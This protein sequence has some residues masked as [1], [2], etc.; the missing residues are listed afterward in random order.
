MDRVIEIAPGENACPAGIDHAVAP[1]DSATW[2]GHAPA[3]HYVVIRG[4]R[5]VARSSIWAEGTPTHADRAVGV[6][7]HYAAADA[8]AGVAVLNHAC[9]QLAR[10]GFRCVVGPMDGNTWRRYRLVTQRGSEPPF[11]LEPDNP[12][13]WPGHFL[14]A[15]FAPMAR[16][17]SA[18]NDD[19]SVV[20]PRVPG[21]LARLNEAGVRIRPIDES[22]FEEE[23]TAVH[24]MSVAAFADNFLY[25]PIAAREFLAMYAPLRGKLRRELVLLAEKDGQLVGYVF[26]MPDLAQAGRGRP[27]D[28]AIAKT[29]AVRPGRAGAGL[30]SVLLDL[31]QQ[32]ARQLGYRRVIHALMHENNR[33]MK[34][35]ARTGHRIRQ[36]ALYAKECPP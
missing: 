29:L 10:L 11:F 4:D 19:L 25:T 6:L 2:L 24:E 20:D 8:A 15:G 28:T 22:R 9:R 18:L 31:F 12:D 13:D 36:Y 16:Y 34:I 30:G 35:S 23:L 7:G 14:A 17:F 1:L 27:I 32:S 26:G 21:A 3:A 5:L 33:S